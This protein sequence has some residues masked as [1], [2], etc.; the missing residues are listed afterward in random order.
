MLCDTCNIEMSRLDKNWLS[1]NDH[2][3]E[4]LKCKQKEGLI[5]WDFQVQNYKPI[6]QLKLT[7][8]KSIAASPPPITRPS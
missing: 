7:N 3:Y 8:P 4:C 6:E 2:Y 1:P 5:Q